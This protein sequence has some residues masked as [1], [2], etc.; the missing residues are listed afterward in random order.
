[1]P[2]KLREMND[3][4]K[5]IGIH[6]PWQLEKEGTPNKPLQLVFEN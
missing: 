5:E 2:I 6:D 3:G 1:M 4:N